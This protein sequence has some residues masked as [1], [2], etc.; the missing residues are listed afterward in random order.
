MPKTLKWWE[1]M[2]KICM[3]LEM[4]EKKFFQVEKN[5]RD[6]VASDEQE[7]NP[8]PPVCGVGA[9]N[10]ATVRASHVPKDDTQRQITLWEN[11]I[12]MHAV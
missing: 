5:P 10:T 12:H 9:S 2:W 11:S 4:S 3:E 8:Q 7:S 6:Q 1:T